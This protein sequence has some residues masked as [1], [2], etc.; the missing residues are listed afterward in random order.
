MIVRELRK[1]LQN[2]DRFVCT[3]QPLLISSGVLL[4]FKDQ[5]NRIDVDISINK[6]LEIK[7]SELIQ[8]YAAF[9]VRFIKLALVLKAWNKQQFPDKMSRLNSF[10]IYLMIIA[11]L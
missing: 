6:V 9:D 8:A 5:M 3:Q 4:C 7:N 2:S 11:F 1:E 10:S